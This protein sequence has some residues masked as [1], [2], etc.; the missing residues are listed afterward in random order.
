MVANP[1]PNGEI[2]APLDQ[3]LSHYLH[4]RG[5]PRRPTV[6]PPWREP[7]QRPNERAGATGSGRGRLQTDS[8]AS[9]F[10]CLNQEIA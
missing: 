2:P 5:I 4:T 3:L 6:C 1:Q 9:S 10:Q 7:G 8:P